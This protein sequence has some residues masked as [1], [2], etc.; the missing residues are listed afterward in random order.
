MV[1]RTAQALFVS[2]LLTAVALSAQQPAP[3][4]HDVKAVQVQPTVVANP[5]KVKEQDAAALVQDSLKDALSHARIEVADGAPVRAHVVL[6][7]FTAGSAAKRMTV[8][9]GSGRASIAC[10]LVLE[11]VSGKELANVP[12]HVRSEMAFNGYK[13]NGREKHEVLSSLDHKLAEEIAKLQ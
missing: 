5:D 8:G 1:R 4:L 9:F 3:A 13:G 12:I 2:T 6:D 11:D 7:E 10:H